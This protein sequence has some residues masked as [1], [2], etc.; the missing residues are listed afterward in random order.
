M[1][2]KNLLIFPLILFAACLFVGGCDNG[3]STNNAAFS[4]QPASAEL[5]D[6]ETTVVLEAVGGH[7][8]LSWQVSDASMGAVSGGGQTVTYTRVAGKYGVNTVTVTDS[9][10]WT[11]VANISQ[12]PPDATTTNAP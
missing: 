2:T 1:I 6:T 9:L 11:A 12:P 8:P 7:Q 3:D 4:I 10:S 5:K